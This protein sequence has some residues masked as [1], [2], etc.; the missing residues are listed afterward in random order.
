MST[1]NLPLIGGALLAF[2]GVTWWLIRA[3]YTGTETCEPRHRCEAHLS[4]GTCSR[5][6]N[7]V[8]RTT[9]DHYLCVKHMRD[10]G[11]GR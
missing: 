9:G 4:H 3:A 8:H 1:D 11:W 5:P 7:Y 6:G 2:V 10:E